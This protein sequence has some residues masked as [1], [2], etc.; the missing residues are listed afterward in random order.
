[1]CSEP[2][3]GTHFAPNGSHIADTE[4]IGGELAPI[5]S[6]FGD[7][8]QCTELIQMLSC[9]VTMPICTAAEGRLVPVCQQSCQ[10]FDPIILNCSV[11][12]VNFTSVNQ[13]LTNFNCSNPQSYYIFPSQNIKRSDS[14]CLSLS[15]LFVV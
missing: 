3:I 10:T 1:M 6:Q 8:H 11:M 7:D 14:E 13:L 12:L 4:I 2:L 9:L 5:V 15:K